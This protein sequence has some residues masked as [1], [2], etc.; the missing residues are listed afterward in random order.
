MTY[1]VHLYNVGQKPDTAF[2]VLRTDIPMDKLYL[3]NNEKTE[4]VTVENQ[5]REKFEGMGLDGVEKLRI[6]PFDYRSVFNAVLDAYKRECEEHDDVR[7]HINFTMGT[8]IMVG[9]VCSAAYSINA[10]LYY[11]Q[12]GIYSDSGKDEVI[13]IEI[14]SLEDEFELRNKKQTLAVF[15]RFAD[16]APKSNENLM[17]G[18][19][20]SASLTYHTRYL[21]EKGLIKR[22][23]SVRNTRW[24]LTAKGEQ[25]IKRL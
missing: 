8:S 25:L 7:F 3:L 11:V 14:E 23:G 10:D 1:H 21:S 4:Y 9:A 2:S 12:E 6:R 24:M 22:E 16:R 20:T 5:I 13:R 17:G 19:K 15:Q 18:L